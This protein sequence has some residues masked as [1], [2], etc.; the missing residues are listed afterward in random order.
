MRQAPAEMPDLDK[1]QT[2]VETTIAGRAGLDGPSEPGWR[3]LEKEVCEAQQRLEAV[4]KGFRF[5]NREPV[6]QFTS[7]S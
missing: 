4:T 2:G 6:E 1:M 7:H 3:Q 5:T